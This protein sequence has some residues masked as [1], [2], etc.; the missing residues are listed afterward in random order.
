MVDGDADVLVVDDSDDLQ[1]LYSLWL[2]PDHAVRAAADG[3]AAL[4][5]LD[6]GVD[7]VLLDREMPGPDGIEVARAI[8]AS[9]HDPFVVMVSSL[10]PDFDL[11]ERP[12]DDYVRKPVEE[13]D[14]RAVVETYRAQQAYL[15]AVDDLFGLARR[16]AAIEAHKSGAELA[17]SEA[18]ARLEERLVAKRREVHE[19]MAAVRSDWERTFRA[20]TKDLGAA[21]TPPDPP[22]GLG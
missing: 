14:I 2:D 4:D 20:C 22:N 8:E 6:D 7:I 12:V 19:A 17:D 21:T 5:V 1:D 9:A 18:Y 3:H 13:A 11:I 10:P 15:R 16:K